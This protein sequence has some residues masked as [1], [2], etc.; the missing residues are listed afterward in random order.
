[1]IKCKKCGIHYLGECWN[2]KG[3]GICQRCEK[4][5]K[6]SYSDYEKKKLICEGCKSKEKEYERK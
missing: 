2:C 4:K 5:G 6:L 3:E 1:M